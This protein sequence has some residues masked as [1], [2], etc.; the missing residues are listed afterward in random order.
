MTKKQ[1]T[2]SLISG[3]KRKTRKLFSSE[4]KIRITIAG[5]R[6]EFTIAELCRKEGI[7][8]GTYSKW[9]QNLFY[10]TNYFTLINMNPDTHSKTLV[11]AFTPAIV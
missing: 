3:M 5:M 10:L 2:S 8:Q 1:S 7:N 9:N 6:G 11:F 4:E